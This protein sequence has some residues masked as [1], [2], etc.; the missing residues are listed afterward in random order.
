MQAIKKTLNIKNSCTLSTLPPE[1]YIQIERAT[2]HA[3][4]RTLLLLA[5]TNISISIH[6]SL[7]HHYEFNSAN[8]SLTAIAL[9]N[10]RH[11]LLVACVN[12]AYSVIFIK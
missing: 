10:S 7:Q 11:C 6:R 4:M 1:T 3:T 9:D 8:L 5:A 2:T 12:F